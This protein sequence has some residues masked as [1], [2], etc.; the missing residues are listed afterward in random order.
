[1]WYWVALTISAVVMSALVVFAIVGLLEVLREPWDEV[2]R[3]DHGSSETMTPDA[4]VPSGAP[5]GAAF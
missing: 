3:S 4:S 5:D 2:I 1:M